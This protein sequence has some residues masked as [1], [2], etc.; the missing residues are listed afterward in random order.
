MKAFDFKKFAN[1][2]F[3]EFEDTNLEKNDVVKLLRLDEGYGVDKGISS[4]KKLHLNRIKFDGVKGGE[5]YQYDQN[6]FEGVN[7]WIGDNN[8]GKTSLFKIITLCLTGKNKL[9]ADVKKWIN[10]IYLEFRIGERIF[11]S[12]IDW[13]SHNLKGSLFSL[14]IDQLLD[15]KLQDKHTHRIWEANSLQDYKQSIENIFYGEL[16]FYSLKYTKKS[17]AKDSLELTEEGTTWA[18]YFKSIFLESAD[19]NSL[20]YGGQEGKVVQMLFGLALT[21]PINR[22]T[23]RKQLK[24]NELAKLKIATN[25]KP[26]EKIQKDIRFKEDQ[27]K[28]INERIDYI[29]KASL[30]N[31]KYEELQK[32]YDGL[33]KNEQ[34]IVS[35][36]SKLHS[37]LNKARNELFQLEARLSNQRND[38][39]ART[40][41]LNSLKKKKERLTE[42]VEIGSF[43]SNL[44]IMHCPHCD[45]EV[46]IEEKRKEKEEGSCS[47][48]HHGLNESNRIDAKDFQQKITQL[49]KEINQ[50]EKR[51]NE[52]EKSGKSVKEKVSN[53]KKSIAK[54][55]KDLEAVYKKSNQNK[56]QELGLQIKKFR[57]SFDTFQKENETLLVQKGAFQQ[58]VKQLKEQLKNSKNN[59]KIPKIELEIKILNRAIELLQIERQERSTSIVELFENT[60][61]MQLHKFGLSHYTEAR[62]NQSFKLQVV[63]NEEVFSFNDTS[64]GE[65][66]RIKL[67]FYLSIIELDISHNYGRH[68]RFIILDTP[69]KEE[70]DAK[71]LT[72]LKETLREIENTYKNHLQLFVGTAQRSLEGATTKA[73]QTIKK[74][75]ETIF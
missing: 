38:Y 63:K 50:L 44:D 72:G 43:F 39:K 31:P 60:V 35:K 51:T 4:G 21:Y 13:Q 27:L 7:I 17:S 61:L 14:S 49:E 3:K 53:H 18:T 40:S 33:L 55:E 36:K 15:D 46:T 23:I 28:K 52:I 16:D 68:P 64:P 25:H 30:K 26:K 8:K 75:E 19:Y 5:E 56:I 29:K 34:A 62:L 22:L 20:S 70:A 57:S 10:N 1:K 37:D 41:D 59:D 74:P 32:E 12:K 2:V 69:G 9:Q 11:T 65:Q 58:E 54:N 24:E 42:Y 48:C 47:L 73:K 71:F 6:F 45:H 66:V 67:A